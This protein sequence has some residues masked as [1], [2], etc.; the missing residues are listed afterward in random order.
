MHET[1]GAYNFYRLESVEVALAAG[2]YRATEVFCYV[3]QAGTLCLDAN[4]VA[5]QEIPATN[6]RFVSKSQ[7]EVQRLVC[8][9]LDGEPSSGSGG[10]QSMDA[11]SVRI[12]EQQ[13]VQPHG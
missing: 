7:H 3:H 4:P 10:N 5:L 8:E 2:Q 13:C 11:R 6:R 9:E 1:E 12:A